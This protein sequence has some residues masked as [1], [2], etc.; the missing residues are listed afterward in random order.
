MNTRHKQLHLLLIATILALA[1]LLWGVN[2]IP[3]AR[4]G[5]PPT[6]LPSECGGSSLGVCCARGYVYY[7]GAPVAGAEVTVQSD[8]GATFTTSTANG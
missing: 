3:T 8:S 4:A 7:N 6:P 1:G 2:H 5:D